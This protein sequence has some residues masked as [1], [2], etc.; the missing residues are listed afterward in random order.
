M[1]DYSADIL[2]ATPGRLVDLLENSD[3]RARLSQIRKCIQV[4]GLTSGTLVLDEADRLLDAGF[5]REL[6]K[7]LES[8]P[9]RAA[10]PRQTLLFSATLPAEVHNVSPVESRLYLTLDLIDCAPLRPPVHQ[11]AQGRGCQCTQTRRARVA[12]RPCQ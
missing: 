2:V 5:R 6:M 3:M 9:D 10:V 8:L 11:H 12:Y 1:T 7:I 4:N